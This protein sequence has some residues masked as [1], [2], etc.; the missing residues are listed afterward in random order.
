[1]MLRPRRGIARVR[2]ERLNPGKPLNNIPSR[3]TVGILTVFK[4]C[5]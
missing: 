2:K 5:H 4:G 1:M 3:G